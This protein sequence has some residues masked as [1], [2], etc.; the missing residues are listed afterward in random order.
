MFRVAV[1]RQSGVVGE[2]SASQLDDEYHA[3]LG[4][5]RRSCNGVGV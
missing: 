5:S 4:P 1:G 2:P 3:R